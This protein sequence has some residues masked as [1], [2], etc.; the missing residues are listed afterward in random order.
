MP[1]FLHRVLLAGMIAH[2]VFL[3]I[4]FK[5]LYILFGEENPSVKLCTL[6]RNK[7]RKKFK[8]FKEFSSFVS[9]A[10]GLVL[11]TIPSGALVYNGAKTFFSFLFIFL[12]SLSLFFLLHSIT[13]EGPSGPP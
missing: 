6:I 5:S 3:H 10:K 12:F 8:Y 7:N 4:I 9:L 13:I 1:N 11:Q 2:V